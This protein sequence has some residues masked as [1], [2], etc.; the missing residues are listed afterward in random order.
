VDFE[1]IREYLREVGR[2]GGLSRSPRKVAAARQN[3]K[4]ARGVYSVVRKRRPAK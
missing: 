2:R 1:T 3:I 4:K